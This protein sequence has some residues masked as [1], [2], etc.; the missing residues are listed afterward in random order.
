MAISRNDNYVQQTFTADTFRKRRKTEDPKTI[1]HQNKK[2]YHNT[3]TVWYSKYIVVCTTKTYFPPE[4]KT[5]TTAQQEQRFH[6]PTQ[7]KCIRKR[8][9]FLY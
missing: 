9:R 2:N 4:Q 5:D 6:Q 8:K 7:S 3:T 1:S